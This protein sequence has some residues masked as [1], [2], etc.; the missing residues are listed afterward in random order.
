MLV[1]HIVTEKR[2]KLIDG[3][4]RHSRVK[5]RALTMSVSMGP[6]CEGVQCDRFIDAACRLHVGS[7]MRRD[8]PVSGQQIDPSTL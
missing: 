5:I 2:R 7:G 6:V 4:N 1:V 8:F 3:L